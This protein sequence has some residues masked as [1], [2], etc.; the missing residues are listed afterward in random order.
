[1]LA[2]NRGDCD[3]KATLYLALLKA[4]H[5]SLDSAFIYINGHAFVGLG[6]KP[7][8]GDMT[9]N[10]DGR[11]WVIAEPVGPALAPLGDADKKSKEKARKGK[12]KIRRVK[13][14]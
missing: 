4:A 3:S 14:D 12:I 11:T 1:L 8:E 13:D 2:K 10:A 7:R 5:P 6:L 9:F